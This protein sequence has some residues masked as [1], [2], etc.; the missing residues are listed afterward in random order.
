MATC[1]AYKPNEK[2]KNIFKSFIIDG[3]KLKSWNQ[4]YNKMISILQSRNKSNQWTKQIYQVLRKRN[5]RVNDYINKACKKIVD[6][7]L[8]ND[9]NNIILGYNQGIK[10]NIEL[11]KINNQNFVNIPFYKI[12]EN[13]A[14]RCEGNKINLIIQEESYTSKANFINND[15]IPIY[16]KTELRKNVYDENSKY[17]FTGKR[18]KRGLY[19]Y[20]EDLKL[21]LDYINADMNGSLNIMRKYLNNKS[22]IVN[23]SRIDDIKLVE[24]FRRVL[25]DRGVLVTPIRIRLYKSKKLERI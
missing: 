17:K 18:I 24:D 12:K 20:N 5:N 3:K 23:D 6:Y 9:I 19:K 14:Y 2:L 25:Y 13:L 15:Y 21:K 11:G 4:L 10:Q 22:N 7:C 8:N 1:V 16:G